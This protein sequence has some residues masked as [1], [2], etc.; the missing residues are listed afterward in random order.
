MHHIKG[1]RSNWLMWKKISIWWTFYINFSSNHQGYRWHKKKG[2]QIVFLEVG[3]TFC[4]LLN[5]CFAILFVL[6]VNGIL[7]C[8]AVITPCFI[9]FLHYIYKGLE[10]AW[11]NQSIERIF[12]LS[13]ILLSISIFFSPVFLSLS[14]L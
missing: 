12:I 4:F 14:I 8:Q 7:L 1:N 2:I 10:N 3:Y 6:T 9:P 13:F 5:C 11:G